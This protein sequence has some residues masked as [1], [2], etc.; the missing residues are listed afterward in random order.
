MENN[1]ILKT[2]VI[3]KRKVGLAL[4]SLVTNEFVVEGEGSC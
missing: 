1:L 3:D 4:V 2:G